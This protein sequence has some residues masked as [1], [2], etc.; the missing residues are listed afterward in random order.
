M[1]S[2]F[3]KVAFA[4]MLFCSLA[5]TAHAYQWKMKS[6]GALTLRCPSVNVTVHGIDRNM[7]VF[8]G[9]SG[10]APTENRQVNASV[11]SVAIGNQVVAS[12]TK[13]DV[14]DLDYFEEIAVSF[15]GGFFI[16][17]TDGGTTFDPADV[18]DHVLVNYDGSGS[19]QR[20]ENSGDQVQTV[21]VSALDINFAA[22]GGELPE[23]VER[24][25]GAPEEGDDGGTTPDETPV[26][27]IPANV[28]EEELYKPG[29]NI[30]L[31]GQVTPYDTSGHDRNKGLV[32][33][34]NGA[35]AGDAVKVA[36]VDGTIK[37]SPSGRLYW[38]ENSVETLFGS[39]DNV[40]L[41][42]KNSDGDTLI[43][44]VDVG[45]DGAARTTQPVGGNTEGVAEGK[46]L[47]EAIMDAVAAYEEGLAK[48]DPDNPDFDPT[49]IDG[50]TDPLADALMDVFLSLGL[51][52]ETPTIPR[53]TSYHA[54]I[55]YP[56]GD[57][58][59][60]VDLTNHGVTIIRG[61]LNFCLIILCLA[62]MY[63]ILAV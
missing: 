43:S 3:S 29:M 15:G 2:L 30:E 50:V 61:V 20:V 52:G 36:G 55:P 25:T 46:A 17:L 58:P 23:G 47:G 44:G 32:L 27:I 18:V 16:Y 34:I 60:D 35:K 53:H 31:D 4:L 42:Y 59:I 62:K 51:A 37:R 33:N 11:P 57:I 63:K 56:G 7:R 24:V 21:Y 13:N 39:G 19:I 38:S 9:V 41:K 40:T 10:K 5:P 22:D 45:K 8:V 26:Y 49:S 12:K 1:G 14:R 28:P 6:T 54:N 48:L